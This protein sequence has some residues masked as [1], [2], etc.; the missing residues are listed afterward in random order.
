MVR[1]TLTLS[2]TY[3]LLEY[4]LQ[5]TIATN[6]FS[7]SPRPGQPDLPDLTPGSLPVLP[8]GLPLPSSGEP[9]LPPQDSPGGQAAGGAG[10]QADLSQGPGR[11]FLARLAHGHL[12]LGDRRGE[13]PRHLSLLRPR[14]D[15]RQGTSCTVVPEP[16]LY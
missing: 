5:T 7:T 6:Y 13:L 14:P 8:A 3:R 15:D 1:L 12:P 16:Y 11:D 4:Y 10:H 2:R 9:G